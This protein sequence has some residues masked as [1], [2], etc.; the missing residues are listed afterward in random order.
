MQQYR[1]KGRGT[2]IRKTELKLLSLVFDGY[3]ILGKLLC[4]L[5]LDSLNSNR[6]KVI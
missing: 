1:G 3:M 2:L 6:S 4:L 5:A